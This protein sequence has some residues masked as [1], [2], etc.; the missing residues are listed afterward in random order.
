MAGVS[1]F[2]AARFLLEMTIKCAGIVSI[3]WLITALGR[4]SAALRHALWLAAFLALLS[5]P[6]FS[7]LLPPLSFLSG[8]SGIFEGASSLYDVRAAVKSPPE[9]SPGSS[10]VD[11]NPPGSPLAGRLDGPPASGHSGT[12][13]SR[14]YP[15]LL[16]LWLAGLIASLSGLGR[17]YRS[18]RGWLADACCVTSGLWAD[19]AAELERSGQIRR[20]IRIL[21]SP[22]IPVP[23]TWGF[24]RPTVAIP[25]AAQTWPA[26]RIR[27]ALLHEV[28]HAR[29]GDQITQL[30]ARIIAA[31][32]WFHPM[33]WYAFRRLRLEQEKACD[34]F[35][36]NTG[37][38]SSSYGRHLMEIA[39]NARHLNSAASLPVVQSSSLAARIRALVDEQSDRRPVQ[40]HQ[41]LR[42]GVLIGC[43]SCLIATLSLADGTRYAET[44]DKAPLRPASEQ[45]DSMTVADDGTVSFI[46]GRL[47]I[48]LRPMTAEELSRQFPAQ[49]QAQGAFQG[50]TV[51]R[52]GV[53][54][55]EYPKVGIDLASI[56][57]RSA[58]GRKWTSLAPAHFER[59]DL[60][61]E[62]L[63]T[64]DAVFS[65]QETSGYIV[66]PALDADVRD[67]QVTVKDVVL[68]YD[69]RGEPV[70]T[71]DVTYRFGTDGDNSA[72]SGNNPT[73]TQVNQGRDATVMLP[74]GATM[75]FVWIEPGTFIMGSPETEEG[76]YVPKGPRHEVTIS[77]GFWLGK[78]ELTQGQWQAVMG[79]TPWSG[80]KYVQSN[81]NHPAVYISWDDV[82]GLIGTL[83]QAAGD[84]LY[85]L[86]TEAEWEYACRAG[87]KNLDGWSFGDEGSKLGDYAWYADNASDAGEKYAHAVGMK[88]PNPWGLHDMHGNVGEWCQDW[89]GEYPDAAQIDP[90]G[91]SEGS[92]RVYRGLGFYS[93]AWVTRSALGG[94]STPNAGLYANGAR[95]VKR[96]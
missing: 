50:L 52:L 3:V 54:N 70:E 62:A 7:I 9:L 92:L 37:Q 90:T 21:V 2:D 5:L 96:R 63:F 83:N 91:P 56:V 66:F 32:Y 42:V 11:G 84:S 89:S 28:A 80:E 49:G 68:R 48:R 26:D 15:F 53:K 43:V 67:I 39:M 73:G 79:S 40:W 58:D 72:T 59:N 95:L 16:A 46:Q 82:Q 8:S 13:S 87:T 76:R 41:M 34:D 1:P 65:G 61:R 51:F 24:I 31:F 33:V 38:R 44:A 75:E 35:V 93:E 78:Y 64:A 27:I 77:N 81:P 86:P 4:S 14:L 30:F 55:F 71:A 18:I 47:E 45:T 57:L 6:A 25:L 17:D 29:R 36:L 74:G 85:R 12:G 10:Q 60:L 22:R 19:I 23:V 94:S 69:Y 20:P 88:Q